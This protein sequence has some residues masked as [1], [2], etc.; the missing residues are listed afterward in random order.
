MRLAQLAPPLPVKS[1]LDASE[2]I[3]G[4]WLTVHNPKNMKTR[5]ISFLPGRHEANSKMKNCEFHETYIDTTCPERKPNIA[6]IAECLPRSLSGT[7][8]TEGEQI[9]SNWANGLFICFLDFLVR[10]VILSCGLAATHAA[11]IH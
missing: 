11:G 7:I 4:S 6:T 8:L 2:R 1:R 5:L 10:N 9:C 3:Q